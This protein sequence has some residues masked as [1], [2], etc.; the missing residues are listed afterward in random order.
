MGISDV[1]TTTA[2]CSSLKAIKS[3]V[4]PPPLAI[5]ITS[6]LFWSSIELKPLIAS[7]IFR[8]ASVP[9]TA[10]GHKSIGVLKRSETLLIISCITEPVGEVITAIL[11]GR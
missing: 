11:D 8:G 4:L 5:I 6:G 2:N 1:L 7:I 9:W 10:T 3:S